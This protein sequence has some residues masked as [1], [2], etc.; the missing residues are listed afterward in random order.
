MPERSEEIWRQLG[1][2]APLADQRIET[3]RRWNGMKPGARLSKG[4]ALFPRIEAPAGAQEAGEAPEPEKAPRTQKAPRVP[5]ERVDIKAF[6]RVDLRVAR[7]EAAEPIPGADKLL[8]VS[9]DLGGEQRELVAGIAQHYEIS[10]LIGKFVVMIANLE[11]VEIRGVRS[12]GMLLAA[13]DG[14]K[15]ALITPDQEMASGAQVR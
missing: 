10:D 7:I 3:L 11:P 2:D 4:E 12:D 5:K 6:D 14:G 9:V 15:L 1:L 8:K 13:G